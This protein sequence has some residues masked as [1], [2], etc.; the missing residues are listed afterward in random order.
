MGYKRKRKTYKLDFSGTEY[1]GLEATLT[2]LTTGEYLEFVSLS[3]SGE[4]ENETEKMLKFFA[5][6]L[7]SWNLED[8][9]DQPVPPTYEGVTSND[10]TMSMFIL[11]AWTDA[12]VNVSEKTEKKSSAGEQLLTDSI[13]TET[14]SPSLLS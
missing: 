4:D 9:D 12:L 5:R 10:L 14:L 3:S 1:E 11:Y 6:H 8:E 13:P 2:G 7:V